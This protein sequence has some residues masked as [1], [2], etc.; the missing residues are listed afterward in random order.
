MCSQICPSIVSSSSGCGDVSVAA[1]RLSNVLAF[2]SLQ[3]WV[4]NG[5]SLI[6]YDRETSNMS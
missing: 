4:K 1:A 3:Q 5:D 6:E 2:Q